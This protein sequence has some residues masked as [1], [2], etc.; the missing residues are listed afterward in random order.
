[1]QYASID[2]GM[3]IEN[4]G[5]NCSDSRHKTYAFLEHHQK[6]QQQQLLSEDKESEFREIRPIKYTDF[7]WKENN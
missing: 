3:K 2:C 4:I 7:D 1:M 6:E 5:S